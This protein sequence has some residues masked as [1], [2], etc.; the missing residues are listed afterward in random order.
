MCR[1]QYGAFMA[2]MV[3][4]S[5]NGS[6]RVGGLTAPP[7]LTAN[8][9]ILEV[10]APRRV[11]DPTGDEGFRKT[12]GEVWNTV[13]QRFY[14]PKFQGVNWDYVHDTYLGRLNEAH[15]RGSFEALIN[16]MLDELHASH[17]QYLTTDDVEYYMLNAVR[18]QDFDHNT[19]AQI[20]VMGNRMPD[21]YHITAVINGG[22]AAAAGIRTG[23]ILVMADGEPYLSA[24]SLRDKQ[25]HTVSITLRRPGQA[26][27][28][29]VSVVPVKQNPLRVFLEA[30]T[31]SAQVL[32]I[33]GKRIGYIHLWTMASDSFRRALEDT[34]L[35]KLHDTD[36]LILDLRDG[37]GGFPFGFS[38][39]FFRPD[40]SWES[41]THESGP[42]LTHTGYNKPMVV[43]ING[44]TRS[45]KEFLT[46]Q[47]KSAHRATILGTRTAGAF[48]GATFIPIG[49]EG[50]LELA[51]QGLRVNGARLENHGVEPDII[52]TPQDIYTDHDA[53][54]LRAEQILAHG[55]AMP[56]QGPG[57]QALIHVN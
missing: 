23:D 7:P 56:E 50:L 44:G 11:R 13:K 14:D 22:P 40:L 20:G 31:N 54:L 12:F 8:V 41:Q 26:T 33:D 1:T 2:V 25:G 27:Q 43:L 18:Q 52:V 45:A 30:T 42:E 15:D 37:Y 16:R 6:S 29:S 32:R 36:G 48:L 53:Q 10:A 39:V 3:C 35:K 24:A 55:A 47:L 38:D 21:G 28:L 4:L 57:D 49:E 34:V 51:I 19:V 46:L 17:T 5:L 9:H